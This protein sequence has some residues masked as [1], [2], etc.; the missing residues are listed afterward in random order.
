M[1]LGSQIKGIQFSLFK[2]GPLV[3][4]TAPV[5]QRHLLA[6]DLKWWSREGENG[7]IKSAA[8]LI[9]QIPA[10]QGGWR[11]CNCKQII[12]VCERGINKEVRRQPQPNEA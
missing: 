6:S 8:F 11:D 2:G 10:R 7:M 1:L 5:C 4:M 12:K 9:E 3:G